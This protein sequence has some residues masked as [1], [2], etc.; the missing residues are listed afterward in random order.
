MIQETN[1]TES[2]EQS[3]AATVGS[4]WREKL[5]K[6]T[7]RVKDKSFDANE[8]VNDFLHGSSELTA[9]STGSTAFASRWPSHHEVR[10]ASLSAPSVDPPYIPL[11]RKRRD[12]TGLHVFFTTNVPEV[13]GEGGDEAELPT[14]D[15]VGS[16]RTS[17]ECVWSQEETHPSTDSRQGP[18]GPS[19]AENQAEEYSIGIARPRVL[20]KRASDLAFKRQSML[21]EEGLTQAK[22]ASTEHGAEVEQWDDGG[23]RRKAESPVSPLASSP[24][25]PRKLQAGSAPYMLSTHIDE[26]FSSLLH[27]DEPSSIGY[28]QKSMPVPSAHVQS[29]PGYARPIT[30]TRN[31]IIREEASYE[32]QLSPATPTRLETPPRAGQTKASQGQMTQH[33]VDLAEIHAQP[34]LSRKPLSNS[35]SPVSPRTARGLNHSQSYSSTGY[36]SASGYLSSPTAPGSRLPHPPSHRRPPGSPLE[37]TSSPDRVPQYQAYSGVLPAASSS[38]S[39]LD[40]SSSRDGFRSDVSRNGS[41]NESRNESSNGGRSDAP[42]GSYDVEEFYSRM[43]HLAEVFRLSAERSIPGS[44]RNATQWL[45]CCTWWFLKGRTALE[46][47]FRLQRNQ[48]KTSSPTEQIRNSSPETLQGYVNVAKSWWIMKEMMP[49]LAELEVQARAN[50][51][52]DRIDGLSAGQIIETYH[53]VKANMTMM[54]WSMDKNEMLPPHSLLSQ[55]MDTRIWIDYPTLPHEV[56]CSSADLH[57][58]TLVKRVIPGQKP[59]YGILLADTTQYFDHGTVFCGVEIMEVRSSQEGF[60]LPCIMSIM[61]DRKRFDTEVVILTQ[62]GQVN[63]HIQQDRTSGLIWND[64]DWKAQES[65]IYVHLSTDF[66]MAV[67]M[68]QSDFRTLSAIF[69]TNS[70]RRRAWDPQSGERLVLERTL[71]AFYFVASSSETRSFPSK[72]VRRCT[73]RLFEVMVTT[74]SASGKRA[75]HDGFRLVIMTPPGLKNISYLSRRFGGRVPVIFNYLRGDENMPALMLKMWVGADGPK[76]SMIFTFREEN[77]RSEVYSTLNGT[78]TSQ[79]ESMSDELALKDLSILEA[80]DETPAARHDLLPLPNLQWQSMAI[81]NEGRTTDNAEWVSSDKLR[82]CM[83]CNLGTIIDRFHLG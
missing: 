62:D 45:R 57:P 59:F 65:S 43:Q 64:V 71:H 6:A 40:R 19:M 61:R 28:Q 82:V 18:Q 75:V 67:T 16:W 80:V 50:L 11:R 1:P 12:T 13:I 7:K 34:P 37:S 83:T 8:N 56:L 66:V 69:E 33:S 52:I 26:S 22:K 31:A 39:S 73:L 47:S 2:R 15:V 30:P 25:E 38:S 36:V 81:I 60:R 55:G 72:P 63:V 4:G 46:T 58:S 17:Q 79:N 9:K 77:D 49:S 27:R 23:V 70:E 32:R 10:A 78:R 74:T 35:S 29:S 53:I 14:R 51:V 54:A 44:V 76:T 48:L 68:T 24:L 20:T 42:K 21:Q 41:R 3:K 5:L